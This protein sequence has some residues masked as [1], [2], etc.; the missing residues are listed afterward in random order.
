MS[1]RVGGNETERKRG[2]GRGWVNVKRKRE[3]EERSEKKGTEEIRK[4]R[5]EKGI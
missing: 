5:I 3:R 2:K 4:R 1:V